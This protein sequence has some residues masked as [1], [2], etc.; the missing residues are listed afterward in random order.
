MKKSCNAIKRGQA[1]QHL[2][3]AACSE[4]AEAVQAFCSYRCTPVQDP[5][6]LRAKL[7]SSVEMLEVPLTGTQV[8]AAP[9]VG[10]NQVVQ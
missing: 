10:K 8:Y 1:R 6:C 5:A 7:I 3:A 2:H 4:S 9:C